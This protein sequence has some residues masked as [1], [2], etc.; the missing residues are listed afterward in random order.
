MPF[1]GADF[2]VT[3]M[4]QITLHEENTFLRKLEVTTGQLEALIS[5]DLQREILHAQ[6]RKLT[7]RSLP[8]SC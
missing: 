3:G 6:K 2:V 5:K 7:H 1:I 4:S 8:W